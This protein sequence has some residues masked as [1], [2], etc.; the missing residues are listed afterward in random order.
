M[1]LKQKLMQLLQ[2]PSPDY[3]FEI[4]EAGIAYVRFDGPLRVDFEAF[5][6]GLIRVSP[7]ADN[8]QQSDAF[9]AK[10]QAIAGG[11]S[12]RK[13]KRAVL[14]LPDFCARVAMLEFDSFP[15]DPKEQLALVRFRMKKSVPF[16]VEAAVISYFPQTSKGKKVDVV[17]VAAALEIVARY[18]APFRAAGMQPGVVTTSVLAMIE[19]VREPGTSIVA[20]LSGRTLTVAVVHNGSLHLVRCVEVEQDSA[21][22]VSNILLPTMAYVE[23]AMG[24]K[25][26]RLLFCGLPATQEWAIEF[27]VPVEPLQSALGVPDA[28][29]AGLLGYLESVREGSRSAA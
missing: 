9:L 2:D 23:D 1:A 24:A 15:A 14:I 13:R 10:V 16:D 22:A 4:S 5:A 6:P 18:E 20:R 21:E 25:A 8:V 26:D 17:V 19:L 28:N 27:D 12:A 7:L 11:G 29:N 3:V